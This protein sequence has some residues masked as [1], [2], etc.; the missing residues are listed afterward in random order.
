MSGLDDFIS[1]K[2]EPLIEKRIAERY[3]DKER[4][5]RETEEKLTARLAKSREY[6]I[7]LRDYQQS[8]KDREDALDAREAELDEREQT[9]KQRLMKDII[10][11]KEKVEHSFKSLQEYQSALRSTEMTIMDWI[12]RMERREENVLAELEEEAGKLLKYSLPVDGYDFEEY[13][14]SFLRKKGFEDVEVTKRSQ[15]FGADV[16]A[17]KDSVKYVFQ[18]KYYKG[19]VGVE[20]IQQIYAAK[21]YYEAHLAVVVTNSV[22]T[23]AAKVLAGEL[24]VILWDCETLSK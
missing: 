5:F 1:Q 8:L 2:L 19:P 9:I 14:A 22:F 18:C 21:D 20:A 16:I 10:E 6:R 23:K 11:E 4:A 15:D 7:M 3:L 13:T 12:K 17:F 24:K